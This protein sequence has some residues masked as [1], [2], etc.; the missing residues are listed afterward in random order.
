MNPDIKGFLIILGI[1]LFVVAMGAANAQ[2]SALYETTLIRQQPAYMLTSEDNSRWLCLNTGKGYGFHGMAGII[3][4]TCT[5]LKRVIEW[6]HCAVKA[7]SA[8]FLCAPPG[9][10]VRQATK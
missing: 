4:L 8:D 1:C 7:D 2:D 5:R 9:V 10:D 6:Q 3:P